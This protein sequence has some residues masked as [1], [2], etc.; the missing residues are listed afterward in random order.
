M[1][2]FSKKVC[3]ICG[4]KSG[5]LS[6]Q[7]LADGNLCK[8]CREKLSPFCRLTGENTVA[9]IAAQLSYREQNKAALAW[10]RPAIVLGEKGKLFIDPQSRKFVL[11]DD[12]E[13]S[14]GNPDLFD[15]SAVRGCS[16]S[17]NENELLGDENSDDRYEYDFYL[18]VELNHPFLEGASF[19]Y[20]G[21]SVISHRR[22]ISET[23]VQQIYTGQKEML[24][25]VASFFTGV[26]KRAT[27][28][29]LNLYGIGQQMM[30]ALRQAA[31]V[32][33]MQQTVQSQPMAQQAAA[34]RF[35]SNCGAPLTGGAFC[36]NCGARVG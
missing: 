17:I 32:P 26:D 35:C 4:E 11:A 7:K 30:G 34:P 15:L 22:R 27:E 21:R 8:N 14:G 20:N 16:L 10:F 25:S 23:E 24:G 33:V 19:R 13:L 18:E 31:G 29:Y 28:E 6:N 9:E 3:S 12:G 2:L 1:A 5:L 36:A